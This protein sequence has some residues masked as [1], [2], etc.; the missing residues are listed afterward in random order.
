MHHRRVGAQL[1]SVEVLQVARNVVLG[2]LGVVGKTAEEVHLKSCE[3]NMDD[4][5][6]SSVMKS[7]QYWG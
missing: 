6:I 4:F 5:I 2:V 7:V 1:K 3:G